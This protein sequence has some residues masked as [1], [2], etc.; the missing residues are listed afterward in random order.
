MKH[1]FKFNKTLFASAL[2]LLMSSCVSEICTNP[3]VVSGYKTISLHITQQQPTR[4][5][6][7]N[8]TSTSLSEQTRGV[9]RPIENGELVQF[10]NGDLYLVSPQGFVIQHFRL[11]RDE[12][13][14]WDNRIINIDTHIGDFNNLENVEELVIHNVPG[15][16]RYVYIM[17]NTPDNPTQGTINAVSGRIIDIVSQHCAWNVNLFGSTNALTQRGTTDTWAGSLRLAPTV[18]RL[19]IA[20]IKGT[21]DIA[22]FDV[23]GIFIDNYFREARINGALTSSL[24][25]GGADCDRFTG[26]AFAFDLENA[27][28]DWDTNGLGIPCTCCN[29]LVTP[30]QAP[31]FP[32]STLVDGVWS[33]QVFAPKNRTDLDYDAQPR[34]I[35]RLRNIYKTGANTPL[36]GDRFV[37]V[38]FYDFDG[39][40]AGTVYR[41]AVVFDENDLAFYPNTPPAPPVVSYPYLAV[42]PAVWVFLPNGGV[43]PFDVETNVS[44]WNIEWQGGAAPAGFTVNEVDL[45]NK[46]FS[47]AATNNNAVQRNGVIRVT[48]DALYQYVAVIQMPG[49]DTEL[50]VVSSPSFVGAFWRENQQGERLIRMPHTTNNAWTAI[51][52]DDWI[53]LCSAPSTATGLGTN[54]PSDAE[55]YILDPASATV[56]NMVTS[57]DTGSTDEI[58]FRIGVNG[59]I[60]ANGTIQPDSNNPTPN[61]TISGGHYTHRWG[62]VVVLHNDNQN[63]HIIWIRQGDGAHYVF[64]PTCPGAPRNANNVARW[65]AFNLTAPGIAYGN[66]IQLANRANPGNNPVWGIKT[67]FPTQAGAFFKWAGAAGNERRAFSPVGT[68]TIGVWGDAA[69]GVWDDFGVHPNNTQETCPPGWRRPGIHTHA[70]LDINSI[71]LCVFRQSLWLNSNQGRPSS[72]WGIYADGFFDRRMATSGEMP[73]TVAGGTAQTAHIGRLFFNPATNYHLFLPGAGRRRILF[74]VGEAGNYW[75]STAHDDEQAWFSNFRDWIAMAGRATRSIGSNI[76]CVAD[77]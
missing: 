67:E 8:Y 41:L 54:N 47:V 38:N 3:P 61:A 12:P 6:V 40:E 23:V 19:E 74:E 18:A 29:L 43:R 2:L 59:T 21:G 20:S 24:T 34:I 63:A 9:S 57:T 65:S 70:F 55:N 30:P 32:H 7:C 62:R 27:L 28:H 10:N 46:T 44:N 45:A 39:V 50:D 69:G 15:Q 5:A 36:D 25:T 52:M 35:I 42:Y 33:Y 48:A 14:D 1:L 49:N 60:G 26:N 68:I 11:V 71:Q 56:S 72:V 22:D 17:G 53:L 16:V 77:E 66:S 64:T 73:A 4:L 13:T 58:R 37:T 51:A 31:D 75:M 76:R